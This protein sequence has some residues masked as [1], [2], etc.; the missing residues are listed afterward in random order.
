MS[1][2]KAQKAEFVKK[3]GKSPSD[4]GTPEVQIAILTANINSL[5]SHFG[6]HKKDNHSRVGLLRMVGKRR[7]LL[8]YLMEKNIERYRKI[9]QELD[10]RK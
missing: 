2:S 4:S 10:I 5:S 6:A 8:D 9:I 7:R 1:I 3:Y